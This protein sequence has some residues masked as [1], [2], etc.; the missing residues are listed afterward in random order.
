M[1]YQQKEKIKRCK[2]EK[3][4]DEEKKSLASIERTIESVYN[5]IEA[6]KKELKDIL[7]KE[8]DENQDGS[9]APQPISKSK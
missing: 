8:K 1:R 9:M 7:D 6:C 4:M 5:K 3:T 2:E